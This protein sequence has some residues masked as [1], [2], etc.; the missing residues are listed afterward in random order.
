[1]DSK[2]RHTDL[3]V[4]LSH[5]FATLF[6][7]EAR[8][9]SVPAT[10]VP[11]YCHTATSRRVES[12]GRR[13]ARLDSWWFGCL[14]FIALVLAPEGKGST[15]SPETPGF[16]PRPVRVGFVIEG[17]KGNPRG[18]CGLQRAFCVG[19]EVYNDQSTW[20]L[21]STKGISPGI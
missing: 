20:D 21:W 17:T 1:M 8:T 5:Q 6:V 18:I 9:R 16:D 14:T 3:G 12:V 4:T 2:D 11:R 10:L 15:D 7:F 13:T 19:C